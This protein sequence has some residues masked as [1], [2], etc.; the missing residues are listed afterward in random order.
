LVFG[1]FFDFDFLSCF[2][3]LPFLIGLASFFF[4][5]GFAGAAFFLD[6]ILAAAEM[7][8][9]ARTGPKPGTE[10]S[11]SILLV[12]MVSTDLKPCLERMDAVEGPIPAMSV[13]GVL[14]DLV[15]FEGGVRIAIRL[16][17]YWEQMLIRQCNDWVA[18]EM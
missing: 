11:A 2:L 16:P 12:A 18:D 1:F 14:I 3:P 5:F 6:V 10:H 8:A 9:P 7:A 17:R 15:L 13:I 4:F